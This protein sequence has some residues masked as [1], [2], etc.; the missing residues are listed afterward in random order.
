[1]QPRVSMIYIN[2]LICAYICKLYIEFFCYVG[3][4]VLLVSGEL[5]CTVWLKS[6][7][8]CTKKFFSVSLACSSSLE[9]GRLSA[10]SFA[11]LGDRSLTSEA[12]LGL[13][14]WSSPMLMKA[15]Q[16]IR[17]CWLQSVMTRV[18]ESQKRTHCYRQ[19]PEK[20]WQAE[21]RVVGYFWPTK[22][23]GG[24]ELHCPLK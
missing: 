20:N 18:G 9:E 24:W 23:A 14:Y 3:N 6:N 10:F 11:Q 13:L 4:L 17:Q 21:I 22:K 8:G 16:W 15:E 12:M 5:I 19:H 7:S 1:M 2:T